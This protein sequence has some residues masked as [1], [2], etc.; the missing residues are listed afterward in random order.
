[1]EL[2]PWPW[3]APVIIKLFRSAGI[4]VGLFILLAYFTGPNLYL[5]NFFPILLLGKI[6]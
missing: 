2:G 4:S 1:M 3:I 6:L 5:L